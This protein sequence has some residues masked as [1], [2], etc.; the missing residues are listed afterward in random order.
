M[1]SELYL[2]HISLIHET[3]SWERKE[4]YQEKEHDYTLKLDIN[5]KQITEE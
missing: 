4:K 1:S 3:I 5:G 2:V